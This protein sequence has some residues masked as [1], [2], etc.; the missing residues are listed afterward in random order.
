[1]TDSWLVASM[2]ATQMTNGKKMYFLSKQAVLK[3]SLSLIYPSQRHGSLVGLHNVAQSSVSANNELV[4]LQCRN[5][6]QELG[7]CLI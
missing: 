1:M 2:D 7:K 6:D 5:V 3:I 4:R